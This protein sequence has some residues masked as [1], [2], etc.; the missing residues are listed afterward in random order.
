M[1]NDTQNFP[2]WRNDASVIAALVALAV[3]AFT[4]T[5]FFTHSFQSRQQMLAQRWF[6]R[7]ENNLKNNDPRS[8]IVDLRTAMLYEPDGPT[9][10]LRLAQALAANGDINQAIAYFLNLWEEQPGQGLYNLE[11]ARLYSRDG[12]PKK[13][14]QFYNSA[15][16]GA[17]DNNP[18]EERRQ[19][20][21]EYID[22]LLANNSKT[23][24][25][26]E[27]ITLT[28]AVQPSDVA[29]RFLA[30]D[31]L[32]KTGEY[33]RALEQYLSLSRSD[34]ARAT[35]GAGQAAFQ[36]GHFRS[37]SKHLQTAIER[38]AKSAFVNSQLQQAKLV[39]ALN[40]VQHRLSGAE[41]ARR[42]ANAYATAGQ[43]LHQCAIATKQRLDI[44]PPTTDL[45]KLYDE[46]SAMGPAPNRRKLANDPDQRDE[47]MDLVSR[48]EENTSRTCG[49]PTGA[50]WALLMLSRFGEGVEQ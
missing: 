33:D 16:Y 26:A 31:V 28:A 24:A 10:R 15:I 40:P 17:W 12:Q 13:A 4:V 22:F 1:S 27:A 2:W 14:T 47:V 39:L 25:Q 30:A 29:A 6:L 19:A 46:W 37:A 8:A 49:L 48:I 45:Q 23:Q 5:L 44:E 21:L 35:L 20:R 41:R 34:P 38:G 50:D 43:R 7:G 9:Y 42:V 3:V 18:A 11:L 32:M 36:L